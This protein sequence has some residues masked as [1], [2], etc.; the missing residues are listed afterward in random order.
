M[1]LYLWEGRKTMQINK[2]NPT[3]FNGGVVVPAAKNTNVKLFYNKVMGVVENNSVSVIISNRGFD[4][5][6]VTDKIISE[7]KKLGV[8]FIQ[9]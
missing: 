2:I 1:I 3:N 6:S 5:S 4:F 9:K 8:V 7:L